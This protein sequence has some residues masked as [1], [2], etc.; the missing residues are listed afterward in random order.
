VPLGLRLAARLLPQ[1]VR[2]EVLGDLVEAWN[3]R[4]GSHTTLSR[5]LWTWKQPWAALSSRRVADA[6]FLGMTTDLRIAFRSLAKAPTFTLAVVTTLAVAI[7]ANTAIFS[8]IDSVLIDP[9]GFPAADRLVFIA[10]SAPGTDRPPEFPLGAEFYV[11]YRDQADA[12]EDLGVFVKGEGT[13][14]A[15]GRA[16]QIFM[17]QGLPSLFTTLGAVPVLGRLPRRDE[18]IGTVAV[19]SHSLWTSWFGADPNV[20][21]RSYDI[22]GMQRTVIGVMGPEFRFPDERTSVW[23]HATVPGLDEIRPGSFMFELVGRMAPGVDRGTLAAQLDALAARL[24]DQV[25]GSPTYARIIENH[26]AVV[27]SLEEHLVGTA[28][29]PLQL[30]FGTVAIV[31]LIACANVMNLLLVRGESRR[32]ELAVRG[33]LGAGRWKLIRLQMTEAIVLAAVGGALGCLL[34]WVGLPLLLRAAP[35]NVPNLSSTRLDTMSLLYTTAVAILVAC[36][37]G[38]V[39]A[40][41]SAKRARAGTLERNRFG[42]SHG[43]TRG[44]LVTLQTASALV[45][46]VSAGLLMRSYLALARMDPGY[47]T[48]NVFTFQVATGSYGVR[49]PAVYLGTHRAITERIEAIPGIESVGLTA[50]LPMDEGA[51]SIRIMTRPISQNSEEPLVTPYTRVAGDYFETMGIEL[52]QGRLLQPTDQEANGS[53]LVSRAAAGM[54]WPGEEAIGQQIVTPSDTT[55]WL[56]VV[57]VVEDVMADDL[58]Q[59]EVTPMIYL[60]IVGATGD[61]WTYDSPVYVIKSE[62]GASMAADVREAVREIVPDAPMFRVFT[63]DELAERS[64]ASLSFTMLMIGLASALALMLGV[65]GLYGVLSFVVNQRASEIAIRVA[66]G[67]EAGRVRRMVVRQGARLTLVGVGIGLV[68]AIATTRVLESLL[69][70]VGALDL[71]TFVV[72]SG[73]MVTVALLASYIPAA[74]AS[75][76]DPCRLLRSE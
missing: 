28:S 70:G 72:M 22:V 35:E 16:E 13:M 15:E 42:R 14:R 26:R 11:Q 39:P 44:G 43:L 64:M 46:L 41:R 59:A 25:G 1:D 40:V 7:G 48:E 66:I 65:V 73:V 9:L 17:V 62:L 63:M 52:E 74:R 38:L 10:G 54:L 55:R 4:H 49:D 76:L 34:A 33:A 50:F 69:F 27:R 32:K 36:L 75:R 18:G 56:T 21:G 31:L 8:V 6:P 71:P 61:L 58:R 19:I 23:I 51:G 3:A 30:L 47:D 67:A 68:V 60:P 5:F 2:E 53:L 45:L 20:I 57:G 37:I 24:P 12:L 29:R